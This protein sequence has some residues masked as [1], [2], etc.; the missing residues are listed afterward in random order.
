MWIIPKTW[1]PYSACAADTVGSIEAL[2]WQ[3]LELESSLM[4]RSKPTQLQTWCRRWKRV[5]WLRHLFGRISKPCHFSRIEAALTSWLVGIHANRLAVPAKDLGRMT[6]DTSG[7]TSPESSKQ[8]DLFDV[9][10][11]T[12]RDTLPKG[13]VTSSA[14]W[15]D[16]VT[17]QRG[18]YSARLQSWHLTRE[19]GFSSWPTPSARD[20]KDGPGMAMQSIDK[21]GKKRNR[22]EQLA[23][24]VYS[25]WPTP[26]Q[27]SASSRTGK[28]KQGGTGLQVAV[29][30]WP[31]PT[32]AEATKISCQPNH[33]QQGLSNHQSIQGQPTRPKMDKSQC[34]QPGLT[35]HSMT[36]KSAGLLNPGWVE[37][38]M[39]LPTGWTDLGCWGTE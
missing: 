29:K 9:S 18:E 10:L 30:L 23:R 27:D 13:S 3:G 16:W 38:L 31:T 34:G 20:W 33:G 5:S 1:Q 36:G 37:Q 19:K 2:S 14:T 22:T 7:Q 24:K 4:W 28:Y 35:R 17:E 32:T 6:P 12:S 39:G 25:L 21:N 15:A 26:T 11:K 8:L